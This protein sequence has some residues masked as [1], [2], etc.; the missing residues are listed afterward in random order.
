MANLALSLCLSVSVSL[1][2]CLFFPLFHGLPIFLPLGLSH[3]LFLCLPVWHSRKNCGQGNS[4]H[5]QKIF[6]QNDD[7]E[8]ISA[9]AG[10]SFRTV[11]STY[12]GA[13][14]YRSTESWKLDGEFNQVGLSSRESTKCSSTNGLVQPW[15]GN[16]AGC[17]SSTVVCVRNL[18]Y[19][20]KAP[21]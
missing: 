19:L 2:V 16:S 1:F 14:V 17:V 21:I 12:I 4:G 9:S 15:R 8:I 10:R 6:D 13:Q 7:F 3:S 18:A 5:S 11:R 20:R